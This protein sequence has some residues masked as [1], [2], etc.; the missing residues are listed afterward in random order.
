[1]FWDPLWVRE[2]SKCLVL[3]YLQLILEKSCLLYGGLHFDIRIHFISISELHFHM[4][5][6]MVT[7]KTHKKVRNFQNFN[8]WLKFIHFHMNFDMVSCKTHN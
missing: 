2:V 4:N 8:M 6:D 5:F 3:K 1:M 7:C